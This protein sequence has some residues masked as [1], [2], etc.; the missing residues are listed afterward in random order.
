MSGGNVL[1]VDDDPHMVEIIQAYCEKE[2]FQVATARSCE[3][4]DRKLRHFAPDVIVLDIMLGEE[5]GIE[6]CRAVR[7]STRAV[8]LFLSSRE[9]D[10]IKIRALADGG[11]DYVTKPFSPKVL[12]AKIKAHL[13]RTSASAG[14]RYL[15]MPGLK[16]DFVTQNVYV[17]GKLVHLSKKEFG[18]LAHMAQFADQVV[19]T[20]ALFQ[21]IWGMDSLEDTRTVAVHISN[22][23]KKIEENPSD[24]KRLVNVR[25]VGYKLVSNPENSGT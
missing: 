20:S 24:P 22:L 10:E 17:N 12:I 1:I 13:R 23:R 4:A 11:D 21:L 8:I 14:E 25:G 15:E 16:L 6:W 3:E 5:N 7:Q 18:I 9:E 19:D 2:G